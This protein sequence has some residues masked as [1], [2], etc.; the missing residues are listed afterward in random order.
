LSTFPE[1]RTEGPFRLL[2][3]LFGDPVMA[4]IFSLERTLRGWL[5]AE[6]AL[7]E[8]QAEVGII[9]CSEAAAIKE[10][11]NPANVDLAGLIEQSKVV[12]YPLLP[13]I[14][15]ITAKLDQGRKARFHYGATTQDIMD[16]TLALQL[17]EAI[18]RLDALL[19]AFG[20]ALAAHVEKHHTTVMVGRTHAQHAVPTTFG[21]KLAVFLGELTR[22]RQRLSETSARTN[23]VSL[24]GAAGTSAALGEAAPALRRSMGRALGLRAVDVPWH[25]ARDAVAEFGLLAAMI[26][27]SCARFARE[28]IDLSRTEIDEVREQGGHHRGASSTMPQKSNPIASE[29]VLGMAV[30]ASAL[31]GALFRAMEA[32]HERAAGEWQIEWQVVPEVAYLA[33]SC[34]A[35]AGEVARRLQVFPEA[36]LRNLESGGGFVMAE[37]YMIR[38]AP[39]I[40]R[41][42]A[43]DLIY[44]AVQQARRNKRGLDDELRAMQDDR[45]SAILPIAPAAYVGEAAAVCRVALAEWREGR[46][47]VAGGASAEA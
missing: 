39:L 32:G 41:E 17:A 45:L 40:G 21:A 43:H 20:E 28:V 34:L 3:A 10:A 11:A 33:A 30:T 27:A 38:L 46:K 24:F 5:R 16:T 13:L 23:R 2:T 37:A 6:V 44:E 42:A 31:S 15:A 8:A 1:V 47:R 35:T 19:D 14:R 29:A 36:M 12:G 7:A 18:E 4:G 9:S 25:V 22:H 26:S